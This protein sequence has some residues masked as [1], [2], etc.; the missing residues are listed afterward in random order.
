MLRQH[1]STAAATQT[2]HSDLLTG[3]QS[4]IHEISARLSG[5]ESIDKPMRTFMADRRFE[6]SEQRDLHG[7]GRLRCARNRR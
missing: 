1:S 3:T 2:T 4:L 6:A 7:Q 5:D